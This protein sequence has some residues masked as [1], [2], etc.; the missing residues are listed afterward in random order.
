MNFWLTATACAAGSYVVGGIPFGLLAGKLKGV[1]VRKIGSGN[2]G[3]MNVGRILGSQWFVAVFLMDMVK[4]L[5]PTIVAGRVLFDIAATDAPAGNVRI[6]CWLAVAICA[7]LGHNYSLF[8]GFRGGKG[9]STSMGVALGIYPELTLPA[10]IGLGIWGF[11]LGLTR[12]SS[13][14]SIAAG[15][16]FPVLYCI[17]PGRDGTPLLERWPYLLFTIVAAL[18][19]VVRHRANIGRILA[20][21]E[22][23]VGAARPADA[24][25]SGS[26]T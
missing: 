7:V 8:L 15:V 25:E 23:R 9:V 3:A 24:T 1:D 13:V 12:M 20:G 11:G 10:L 14:G 17:L 4:G 16:M 2:V 21:T 19:V 22:R 5:I 6:L 26:A 18:M